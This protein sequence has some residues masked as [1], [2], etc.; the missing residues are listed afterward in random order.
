MSSGIL[1]LIKTGGV[2]GGALLTLVI[3]TVLMKYVVP[4]LKPNGSGAPVLE[5]LRQLATLPAQVSTLATELR[6][7]NKTIETHVPTKAE[8]MKQF[9]EKRHDMRNIVMEGMGKLETRKQ[10]RHRKE[11]RK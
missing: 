8:L 6:G 10:Q 5:A 1:E 4:I 9:E 3:L 7:F 11:R 2:V